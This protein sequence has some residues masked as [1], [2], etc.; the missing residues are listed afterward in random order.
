MRNSVVL[1]DELVL[2]QRVEDV[3]ALGLHGSRDQHDVRLRPERVALIAGCG[4]V[5]R[6]GDSCVEE[7]DG[8]ERPHGS[9]LTGG[10]LGL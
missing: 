9:S 1:H 8:E 2:L 6:H 5:L 4:R 3:P 7:Q 10:V